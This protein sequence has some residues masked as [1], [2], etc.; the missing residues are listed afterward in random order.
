MWSDSEFSS[1]ASVPVYIGFGS[2]IGNRES[3]LQL[4][5]QKVEELSQTSVRCS[6]LYETTPV[7]YLDQPNFLNMV[8][9]IQT[10]LGPRI[11][12]EKLQRIEQQLDR[13]RGIRFGPRTI[14]LD[15]LLYGNN[16]ECFHDLQIPHPRMWQ[17]SFVMTPL[18]E[19]DP[20]RR[21]LGGQTFA[22]IAAR[23]FKKGD[24][25]YAGRLR[26]ETSC[27]S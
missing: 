12:L 14:D 1:P 8:A 11:L 2:N 6:S 25:R 13:K 22:S 24:V 5:L 20:T 16:Y 10:K 17:R 15:I 9:V 3:Y 7:E 26:K 21:G 18:A 4:A 19:L 27:L 23:I